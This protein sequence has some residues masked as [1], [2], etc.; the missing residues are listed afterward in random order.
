MTVLEEALSQELSLSSYLCHT[1]LPIVEQDLVGLQIVGVVESVNFLESATTIVVVEQS[2]GTVGLCVDYLTSPNEALGTDQYPL[3]LSENSFATLD[4][5]M[6]FIRLDLSRDYLQ[7]LIAD[8]C[9]NFLTINTYKGLFRYIPLPF[10]VKTEPP[11][12]KS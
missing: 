7:I 3:S 2:D 5:G 12:F 11:Y 8:E 4:E 6:Y 9:K 10:G 1:V